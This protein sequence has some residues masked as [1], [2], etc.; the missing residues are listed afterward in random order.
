MRSLCIGLAFLCVCLL[1]GCN[2]SSK[3]RSTVPDSTPPGPEVGNPDPDHPRLVELGPLI[4]GSESWVNGTYVWT[5]YVYDDHGANTDGRPGGDGEDGYSDSNL[6]AADIVQVQLSLAEGGWSA[7]FILQT[8][9][10]AALP[11]LG[12]AVDSDSNPATGAQT[13]PGWV[14]SG[15]L[16]AEVMF[17][18]RNHIVDVHV[19]SNGSWQLSES[20][21]LVV[22][23]DNNTLDFTVAN[24]VVNA[25]WHW[26]VFSVAGV[27]TDGKAW[28]DGGVI[29]D[30]AFVGDERPYLLQTAR[31]ADVLAGSLDSSLAAANIDWSNA[32]SA[33]TQLYE[34]P[35]GAFA[36]FLHRSS[37][38][39][40]EGIRA[41]SGTIQGLE[42]LGPYQP[43]LVWLPSILPKPVALHVFLHGASQNHLGD[44]WVNITGW[45]YHGLTPALI[46][47][48]AGNNKPVGTDPNDV[49]L[50]NDG[51]VGSIVHIER[52]FVPYDAPGVMIFPLGRMNSSGYSG[53]YEADVFEAI[54]DIKRRITI[55]PA[56]ISLSGSSMGGIGSFR[57]GVLYPDVWSH[58]FPIVGDGSDVLDLLGNLY[59]L[60]VR[61]HNGLFDPL[62]SQPGPSDSADALAAANVD[63]RY[64]LFETR[65]HE[66]LFPINHCV[67]DEAFAARRDS[68]PAVVKYRLNRA[69]L[70]E[71]PDIGL[72]QRYDQAYWLSGLVLHDGAST[73]FVEAVNLKNRAQLRQSQAIDQRR[74]NIT[75]GRDECGVNPDVRTLDTWRETGLAV[76][77][78][79]VTDAQN[80][81]S[82]S[83][84]DLQ[85]VVVDL[86]KLN[87]RMSEPVIVKANTDSTA[88]LSLSSANWPDSLGLYRESAFVKNLIPA[89]DQVSYELPPGEGNYELRP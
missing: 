31:Q 16:G 79:T 45:P 57:L 10:D 89:S 58:V 9:K 87:I 51:A 26:R 48:Y 27:E 17:V 6:N 67:R 19:F 40:P 22:D 47:G 59:N 20:L 14:A 7:R 72:S 28:P 21:P 41:A 73:G 35:R 68:V 18:L 70:N 23:L 84:S 43:Y 55:D 36:T 11:V 44:T 8:L 34:A 50:P 5:D 85:A 53:I 71:Q 12:L 83:L 3:S 69:M 88:L 29:L 65:E 62:V 32:R 13:L 78:A 24:T 63:Y 1:G 4:S 38:N 15:A 64:W 75:Q 60:P 2:D 49:Y 46:G 52:D 61:M 25:E 80:G 56:R 37:L 30:M 76:N 33:L 39:L 86:D 82:I 66:S 74:E 81:I 42:Y 54:A 77:A